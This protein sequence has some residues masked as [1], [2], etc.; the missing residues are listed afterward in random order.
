MAEYDIVEQNRIVEILDR[1]VN[2]VNTYPKKKLDDVL[3]SKNYI[4]N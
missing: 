3:I 1:K 4:I 2:V